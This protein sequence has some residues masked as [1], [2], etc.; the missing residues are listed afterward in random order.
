[1]STC[2][3]FC[4]IRELFSTTV[5]GLIAFGGTGVMCTCITFCSTRQLFNTTLIGP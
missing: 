4:W 3:I 5:I 1:V 2:I